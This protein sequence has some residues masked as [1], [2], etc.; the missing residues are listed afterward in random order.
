MVSLPGF[1][2]LVQRMKMMSEVRATTEHTT[3]LHMT[4]T[5]TVVVVPAPLSPSFT[6]PGRLSLLVGLPV[7][8]HIILSS[9]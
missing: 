1:V 3:V 4:A 9:C 5:V 8:S 7:P 6:G 2:L